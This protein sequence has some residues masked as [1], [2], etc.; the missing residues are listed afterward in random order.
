MKR[1][2]PNTR[3][4]A[5]VLPG[6]I[7]NPPTITDTNSHTASMRA[8]C[9]AAAAAC[10]HPIATTAAAGGPVGHRAGTAPPSSIVNA[11][12]PDHHNGARARNRRHHPRTV[13][14]GNP[15]PRAVA[16]IDAPSAIL[17]TASPIVPA[18]S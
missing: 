9:R 8:G 16:P 3:H 18:G 6:A 5:V 2:L 15:D 17:A 13:D 7:S 12:N 11:A 1:R 10:A 14:N 4:G